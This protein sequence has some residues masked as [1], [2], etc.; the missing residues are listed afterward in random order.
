M[1]P[2]Q[3]IAIIDADIRSGE[4]ELAREQVLARLHAFS[5]QSITPLWVN[6]LRSRADLR[7]VC[8]VHDLT[9]LDDFLIDVL[10][11]ARGVIGTRAALS[12][13]GRANINR[14]LEIPMAAKGQLDAAN[15]RIKLAPGYDRE[16]FDAIWKLP[17]HPQVKPVW[18]LRT[19]HGFDADLNMLLF[20]EAHPAING[21]ITSW[22]R[23]VDGLIDTQLCDVIDWHLLASPDQMIQLA[24]QFFEFNQED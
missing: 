21:Y 7:V 13:G 10:R 11:E 24:E 2:T 9:Q 23:P 16:A 8:M 4:D 20:S 5:G 3:T 12:F 17:E 14:L 22:L 18:L 6:W 19:Y 15:V 1:S